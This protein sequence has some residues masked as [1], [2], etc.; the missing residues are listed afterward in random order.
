MRETASK[1]NEREGRGGRE[2]ERRKRVREG[3]FFG[4]GRTNRCLKAR[5]NDIIKPIILNPVVKSSE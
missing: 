1:E 3:I 4:F 5:H 2:E